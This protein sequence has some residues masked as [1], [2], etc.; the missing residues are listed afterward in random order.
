M[1]AG[2]ALPRFCARLPAGPVPCRRRARLG[3][4]RH[5]GGWYRPVQRCEG[6]LAL[7]HACACRGLTGTRDL[8]GNPAA[9]GHASWLEKTGFFFCLALSRTSVLSSKSA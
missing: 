2:S 8:T 1:P 9:D 7:A 3:S 5:G 6:A 4:R